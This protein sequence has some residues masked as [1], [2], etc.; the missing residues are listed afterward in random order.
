MGRKKGKTM[1]VGFDAV[2]EL[3]I[4]VNIWLISQCFWVGERVEGGILWDDQ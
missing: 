3:F 2:Y 4:P 1:M